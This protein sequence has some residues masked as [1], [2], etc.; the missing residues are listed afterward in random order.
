MNMNI[1]YDVM[2]I[3]TRHQVIDMYIR[4]EVM[5]FNTNNNSSISHD[6]QQINAAKN[7]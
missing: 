6:D 3:N 2:V 5:G 1:R 4:N 7:N